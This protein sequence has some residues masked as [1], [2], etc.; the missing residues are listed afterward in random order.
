MRVRFIVLWFFCTAVSMGER[1]PAQTSTVGSLRAV[2]PKA[3]EAPRIDGKLT[4]YG[5][6]FCTPLEYFNPDSKNRPAQFFYLWDDAAFYVGVRTLDEKRFAPKELFWT[7]DAVEWYFDTRGGT[8]ADRRKWGPEAV[9][10]F[11]TPL[12]LDQIKPRFTLRSGYENAIPRQGIEVAAQPTE[13]G[14]EYEFK[15]PWSNFPGFHAAAGQKLH[16]DSELSCSDGVSR[17][18]RSFVFGGPLSV[19]QPANLARVMLVDNFA[20]DHWRICGPVMMPIRVDTA[21]QQ[22]TE[23]QVHASIAMP[24]N[25]MDEVGEI[26]FQLL[27]TSGEVIATYSAAD[28]EV[29]QR[30]G[31]FVRRTA[32]W[33]NTIAA[34]GEY[35]VQAVVYDHSGAELTRVA[36]RLVSVNMNQGY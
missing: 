30:Q 18:F 12:E 9:H 21:W 19:E 17:S 5:K 36:P 8:T 31:N 23:P 35:H 3:E 25:R 1:S 15:L 27:N 14:L 32:R 13:Y 33:R 20:R 28:E 29:L 34:P 2:I 22:E 10:C 24:P 6:A 7:G 16:L 11:F 26:A 4:E